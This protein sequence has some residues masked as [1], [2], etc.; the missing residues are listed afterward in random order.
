MRIWK[1][2][3]LILALAL[4]FRG[5]VALGVDAALEGLIQTAMGDETVVEAAVLSQSSLLTASASVVIE[6]EAPDTLLYEPASSTPDAPEEGAV[7]SAPDLV[8]VLPIY[9]PSSIDRLPTMTFRGDERTPSSE[10]VYLRNSTTYAVD[11]EAMLQE[12]LGFNPRGGEVPT[13]LILHT[14]GTE[15]FEPDG[16][17]WYDNVDNYRTTDRNLNIT[18]VGRE[19]A[20]IFEARGIRV[21]H[22]EEFHDYPAFRGSYGRSL[23]TAEHYLTMYPEIQVIFDIHRDAIINASG[24]YV[25]TMAAIEGIESAQ[26]ML[27][28]GTDHAGL[29]HPGWRDNLRFALRLQA[30][31]VEYHPT[32]ARPMSLREERFNAHVRPGAVLVEVGTCANTLQEAL[33]ASRI[34]AEIAADVILGT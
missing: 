28:V 8:E 29:Y 10:G 18:R 34:F 3:A 27:V 9:R 22:S 4:L 20:A 24:Q 23:L 13:V 1:R 7:A 6:D 19:I 5:L 15:S 21:I 25:R 31:M 14:H 2:I 11:I 17:D 16:Y 12:P 32:F 33:T 26:I 30:A